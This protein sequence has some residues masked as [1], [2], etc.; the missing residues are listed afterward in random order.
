MWRA[1]GEQTG[2]APANG[3]ATLPAR[4]WVCMR[5]PPTVVQLTVY[6]AGHW[7][8]WP[9]LPLLPLPPPP[10]LPEPEPPPGGGVLPADDASPAAG[11]CVSPAP[12]AQHTQRCSSCRLV[13]VG[14]PTWWRL[15]LLLSCWRGCC[16]ATTAGGD[17]RGCAR[18]VLAVGCGHAAGAAVMSMHSLCVCRECAA[19]VWG[20]GEVAVN[21]LG[22]GRRTS[23]G[24]AFG[25][26]DG[27]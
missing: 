23:T 19:R 20:V 8:C 27:R 7:R 26:L 5:E 15:W 1:W 9:G 2:A 10:P 12:P 18:G 11:R 16:A 4:S 3:Q 6:H 17:L 25:S 22:R 21:G 13:V 14:L 24:H